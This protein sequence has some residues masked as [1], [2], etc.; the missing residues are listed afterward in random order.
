MS[1][2]RPK[3][4]L[5]I[6]AL[7]HPSLVPPDDLAALG[8]QAAYDIKT[9]F[10]VVSTLRAAGHEVH[11]LGV[12]DE[13][14]PIRR[15][16]EE[17]RPHVVFNLL[18][19]FHGRREFDQHVVSYLELLRVPYTGCGPRGL[20][21]SRDKALAKQI[22]AYHR[23][24]SP[25]FFVAPRSRRSSTARRPKALEFPLIVKSLT[26]ESSEGISQASVVDDDER[27]AERV[28]FIHEAVGSDALVEQYID[29]REL[30]VG[31]MGFERPVVFPPWELLFA[32]LAPGAVAIA[33][34]RVKHDARY[35]EERGILQA[36]AELD[37]AVV[38]RIARV[39]R[40]IYKVL[41]LDG[42][43][44]LDFRL[45]A[46]GE[47]Y[48]LEANPNPDVARSE[49]FASAAEARGIDYEALLDRIVHQ[50]MRAQR[51]PH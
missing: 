7:M 27:L 17:F 20:M 30:Y 19:E 6:L 10:D 14:L 51:Q 40:R 26:E 1:R 18:E 39:S 31:V 21:L 36:E 3:A 43:A 50:G 41:Y 33:T 38:A 42:Y 34:S 15:A 44:R 47:P 5:R 4:R 23:I 11:T 45:A 25:K 46:D 35:Q 22:L 32:N 28:A 13:L 37:P 16:V 9:E 8:T 12:A 2:R 49:E 29:G 24:R 48:F